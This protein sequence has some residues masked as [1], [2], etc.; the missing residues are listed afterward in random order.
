MEY[1][2]KMNSKEKE[3]KIIGVGGM[4][5]P[6][7]D[8]RAFEWHRKFGAVSQLPIQ[9]F[10]VWEPLITYDQ[11]ANDLCTDYGTIGAGEANFNTIFDVCF[12]R[13]AHNEQA[14]TPGYIGGADP[15]QAGLAA[16]KTGLL[17]QSLAPF[18]LNDPPA[19]YADISQYPVN[20]VDEAG[21][22]KEFSIYKILPNNGMDLF[23][24]IRS[25]LWQ[26]YNST[27]K[28][29]VMVGVE[30]RAS[31][32]PATGGIITTNNPNEPFSNHE[33]DIIGQKTINGVLYLKAHLSSGTQVGDNGD[34][35]FPREIVNAFL[36]AQVFGPGNPQSYQKENWTILQKI[37]NILLNILESLMNGS[38]P[39]TTIKTTVNPTTPNYVPSVKWGQYPQN[40]KDSLQT[41]GLRICQ[42]L[43][44]T[45]AQIVDLFS[46]IDC[47]SG[48][49]PDCVH[50]NLVDGKVSTT[51][52]G[53]CQVN[54]YWHIGTGK[55]FPTSQYVLENPLECLKWMAKEFI[56]G[57]QHLWVCYLRGMYK[58]YI[59]KVEE[60]VKNIMD[61][62][63][64]INQVSQ[65]EVAA[66]PEQVVPVQPE[67]ADAVVAPETE[68]EQS[69]PVEPS[70]PV[71]PEEVQNQ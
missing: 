32:L 6:K 66:V 60:I 65:E 71:A 57:N 20:V 1:Y 48:W 46:T 62:N 61:E 59:P 14:G 22:D 44:M 56:D 19:K 7:R 39:K 63:Q 21:R 58:D 52:Y 35:Y 68:P 38:T 40:L 9:D 54:D 11:G 30:W 70:L 34:F 33:F 47:E 15:W 67:T 25:V 12:Q 64:N 8:F 43:K 50:R 29:P 23:D 2:K 31:W 42:D 16:V 3:T 37:Y 18:T 45:Q 69:A 28:S 5:L 4:K 53:L 51:D 49:N 10:D 41:E 26:S 17:P 55:S 24:S 27:F 13:A 36:F